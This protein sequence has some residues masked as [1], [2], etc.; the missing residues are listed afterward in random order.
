M[1]TQLGRWP[2]PWLLGLALLLVSPRMGQSESR[3]V[4]GK[5]MVASLLEEPLVVDPIAARSHTD[6]TVIALL[7]DTLYRVENGKVVPHLAA[8][9][10]DTSDPLRASIPLRPGV[11]FHDGTALRAQDVVASLERLRKSKL[12]FLLEGVKGAAVGV[13]TEEDAAV[14]VVLTLRQA[15]P[16]L[17]RRLCDLHTSI[18]AR[19]KAPGWRR[20]VGS[21]AWQLAQRS[22]RKSALILKPF[23]THFAGRVYLDSLVL[24]WHTSSDAE[25]RRYEAGGS[26]ISARGDI[27][28][29]GHRP[30][31]ATETVQGD[32]GVLSYLGFGT[33]SKITK[34]P[35]FRRAVSAAMGR[36][37]MSQ[38]GSGESVSPT[39]T[40]LRP[41]K[42]PRPFALQANVSAATALLKSLSSR[43]P[44]IEAKT[45]T[46]QL[47]VNASRPDDAVIAARV[48]AG[49]YRFGI[50]AR[51]VSLSAEVFARRSRTGDCDL[52]IGQLASSGSP[53]LA[54]LRKAFVVGG[55]V[56]LATRLLRSSR[57][58]MERQF[59]AI[60]PLVPLFHRSLRLHIR[61]DVK[62]LEFSATNTLDYTGIFLFGEPAK[63]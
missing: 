41:R 12:G 45:L 5:T 31:F 59:D 4:Y 21:G 38:I 48:A 15:D 46:L 57:A 26:H 61:N 1:V 8:A 49:L 33:A 58:A 2:L 56:K 62:G 43:Y 32:V 47:I 36:A 25:A 34:E 13:K 9:L 52:Y 53:G 60:V 24:N 37:G 19:G 10:P 11:R 17:A 6:M 18:V 30:K 7:F 50:T 3:P 63:N 28:F 39:T 27:A 16:G 23:E 29:A 42:A 14:S 44:T 55:N 35:E 20:L 54:H 22:D 51:I 40:V